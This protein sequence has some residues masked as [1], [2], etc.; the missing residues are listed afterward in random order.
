MWASLS[1]EYWQSPY[2]QG[3]KALV[4][5][6]ASD[7][8][9]TAAD[10]YVRG[11]PS[12]PPEAVDW[13]R[14]T[15]GLHLGR[16]VLEVGAGTGKFLPL[17]QETGAE[18]IALEPVDAMRA[19]ID[20]AFDVRTLGGSADQIGLPDASVDVVVC[21]Q[22]FHWFATAEAVTE[23]RRVLRPGGVLGLIWNG[24]DV[25]VPWVASM[26]AILDRYEGDTPRFQTGRWRTVFPA[27]G[28]TPLPERHATNAH[29]GSPDRVII[30][31]ALSTSFIAA[32][33]AEERADVERRLRDLIAETPEL[34]GR[35]DV[36]L[37]YETL[38][39]AFRKDHR[40]EC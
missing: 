5:R 12:Y 19:K 23:M 2:S 15:L 40:S 27:E 29:T 18:I 26:G 24:R 28:L 20:S 11:R 22:A 34:A 10:V 25:G 33:P 37:P 39:V 36:T 35:S 31:R 1:Y 6:A 3:D 14:K 17:L 32:L 16:T 30:D 9:S 38:M 13:L 4:H 7:G 8:Y 21:A